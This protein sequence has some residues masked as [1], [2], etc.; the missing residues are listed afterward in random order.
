[1]RPTSWSSFF[2]PSK[3]VALGEVGR[4]SMLRY[5]EY[6]NLFRRYEDLESVEGLGLYQ[7]ISQDL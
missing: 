3:G 2:N 7:V 4:F 5:V 1:M 6:L